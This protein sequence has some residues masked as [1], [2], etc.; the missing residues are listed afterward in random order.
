[1]GFFHTIFLFDGFRSVRASLFGNTLWGGAPAGAGDG[2]PRQ[3]ADWLG[4]TGFFDSL[5]HGQRPRHRPLHKGGFGIP[6]LRARGNGF[7]RQSADWLGMTPLRG[8]GADRVVR[9]YG[10]AT[11]VRPGDVSPSGN[12]LRCHLPHRG[13][14]WDS[15]PAGAENGFPRQSADWLGMTP[16]RGVGADRVV[17]PY[18]GAT[19][20]R[21]GDVS[22]SGNALRCHLPHRGRLWDS[23]P[24]GAENGF[25]RQ[26]A[27]WLGMTPLRGVRGGQG[28]PPLRSNARGAVQNRNLGIAFWRGTWYN[29]GKEYRE[30]SFL[31]VGYF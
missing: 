20:V 24:A 4:M 28:R 12:A 3:S 25:P 27:D 26:S 1:M 31:Y 2:L 15:A 29:G 7:P 10:G 30:R 9:P 22:P 13:R 5:R 11:K 17:R 23:A 21:P 19:K 6:R 16:L 14:L 18:G 8:V